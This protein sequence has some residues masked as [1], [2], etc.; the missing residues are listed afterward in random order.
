M[1][2]RTSDAH[3]A[4]A[5]GAEPCLPP[6]TIT[7]DYRCPFARN[8]HEHLVAALEA[9]APYDVTFFGYSLSQGHLE[10]GDLPV[11]EE[12]A[13]DSGI[14]AMQ[15]GITV[16]DTWPDQFLTVHRGLF[17][18]RHDEGGDLRDEAA[19]RAVLERS[20][21]DPESVFAEIASGWPLKTFRKEH[22]SGVTDHSVWGVPTFI[23]KDR[24]VFV[25]LMTRP[26]GDP[27]RSRHLVERIIG[28]MDDTPELNE[29]KYTT[30]AN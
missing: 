20:G 21:V 9:G 3:S 12:P 7:W 28:L 6:F 17:A 5:V 4:E 16:R 2:T 27:A 1:T 26:G 14:L 10:E 24:A 8:A 23:V 29:F 11:W 18:L 15:V 19:L 13:K 30:I 25:R 22:E